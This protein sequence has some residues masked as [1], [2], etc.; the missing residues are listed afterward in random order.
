MKI[1]NFEQLP[2]VGRKS[3]AKTQVF[4]QVIFQA[5]II[6]IE[7]PPCLTKDLL[8]PP[9]LLV[10]PSSEVAPESASSERDLCERHFIHHPNTR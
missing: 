1:L 5:E 7:L 3:Q 8:P 2:C 10:P 6:S 4:F 9:L